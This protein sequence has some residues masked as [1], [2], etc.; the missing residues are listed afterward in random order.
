VNVDELRGVGLTV[1]V[2]LSVLVDETKFEGVGLAVGLSDRVGDRLNVAE[3]VRDPVG[4]GVNVKLFRG[5]TVTEAAGVKGVRVN[6]MVGV[7]VNEFRGVQVIEGEAVNEPVLVGVA[8]IVRVA[9]AEIV[10]VFVG[11]TTGEA[12]CVRV[13]VGLTVNERVPVA[14][15]VP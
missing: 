14:V 5:E 11:L 4:V 10:G 3:A 7:N 6:V 1:L 2:G 9:V 8:V 12:V 15:G 13:M